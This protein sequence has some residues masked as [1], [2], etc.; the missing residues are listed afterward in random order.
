MPA[1]AACWQIS[2]TIM[3]GEWLCGQDVYGLQ[4]SM[5][6]GQPLEEHWLVP[7]R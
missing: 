6:V 1:S 2:P 5:Q 3:E 7:P 4:P